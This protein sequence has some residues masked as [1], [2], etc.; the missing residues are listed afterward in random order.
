MGEPLMNFAFSSAVSSTKISLAAGCSTLTLGLVA[1]IAAPAWADAPQLSA[2]SQPNQASALYPLEM[3]EMEIETD[4]TLTSAAAGRI[5][6]SM[7]GEADTEPNILDALG[8]P[9]LEALVNN[10]VDEN[11]DVNL[12]LGLTFYDTMGD[13]SFGFGGR[14]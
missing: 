3:R 13:P 4:D 5:N 6:R 12:P 10:L 9:E 11:G 1:G 2:S 14:F 8:S 7:R